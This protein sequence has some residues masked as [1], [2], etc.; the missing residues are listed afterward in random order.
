ML[1]TSSTS[2]MLSKVSFLPLKSLISTVIHRPWYWLWGDPKLLEAIKKG[3]AAVQP[4]FSIK[5]MRSTPWLLPRGR[6]HLLPPEDNLLN[7]VIWNNEPRISLLNHVY[8]LVAK[9][10]AAAYIVAATGPNLH[11]CLQ[12]NLPCW[13]ITAE[14]E[15]FTKTRLMAHL[16]T[17]LLKRDIMHSIYQGSVLT[18]YVRLKNA[19]VILKQNIDSIYQVHTENAFIKS[20]RHT[21][22]M[23]ESL[24]KHAT[25]EGLFESLH[26][27]DGT[28]GFCFDPQ[29]CSE[30][31]SKDQQASLALYLNPMQC[32]PSLFNAW[33]QE[34]RY[35][36]RASC[37]EIEGDQL[38]LGVAKGWLLRQ[39][40]DR[41]DSCSLRKNNI[42]EFGPHGDDP[43]FIAPWLAP[44]RQKM[45]H[46]QGHHNN[47]EELSGFWKVAANCLHS[48]VKYGN[49]PNHIIAALDTA[50][51]EHCV[52]K[53]LPCVNGS[54]IWASYLPLQERTGADLIATDDRPYSPLNTGN[55]L[56]MPTFRTQ[57]LY[58]NYVTLGLQRPTANDQYLFHE[59]QWKNFKICKTKAECDDIHKY[60]GKEI[61]AAI[62]I[63]P[64]PHSGCFWDGLQNPDG[65]DKYIC[66]THAEQFLYEHGACRGGEKYE[67]LRDYGTYFLEEC[68]NREDCPYVPKSW[69]GQKHRFLP[70]GPKTSWNIFPSDNPK[71]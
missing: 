48:M 55:V 6:R 29:G 39:C 35:F 38:N 57:A 51:L 41:T 19:N 61:M 44:R 32:T 17:I 7:L 60:H 25:E 34:D 33:Q 67:W 49:G 1:M 45:F 59:F 21:I 71:Q 22:E 4:W 69:L 63:L 70:C 40:A 54:D 37:L 8:S 9:G 26:T 13:D 64:T 47:F 28:W 2:M 31:N 24:S 11:E 62:F 27:V 68:G 46:W 65:I 42:R 56:L 23:F 5:M 15:K 53:N 58:H 3:N 12:L 20:N 14:E 36:L 10:K 30:V 43:Y 66:E 18:S 16:A 52:D 50:T